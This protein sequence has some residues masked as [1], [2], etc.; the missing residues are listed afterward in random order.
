VTISNGL[1]W[2]PD[3]ATAY[4]TDTETNRVDR[5]GYDAMNGLTNRRTFVDVTGIGRPDGLTVDSEGGVW[6]ALNTSGTVRRYTP[7]GRLDEI[8]EVPA[9]TVTACTL[10][11]ERL[12]ELFI[13]TSRQELE[14]GDDPLAGSLFS[15]HVD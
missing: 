9:Q 10:G 15:V 4:Y 11:G 14:P 7:D 12:D 1:D 8:I 6:V 13:T 5:F 2:A 3:G